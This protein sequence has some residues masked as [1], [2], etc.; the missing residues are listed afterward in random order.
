[1]Y[2]ARDTPHPLCA[3]ASR[4]K[5][6]SLQWKSASETTPACSA[7]IV[8]L[9]DQRPPNRLLQMLPAADFELARPHL[10]VA[11]LA[12]NTLLV[13]AGEPAAQVYLP[14][15]GIISLVI[16]LSDGQAIEVAMIGRDGIV[17]A[18]E[19]LCDGTSLTDAVVL[20]P[21]VASVLAVADL[22]AIA[23]RSPAWRQLLARHEQAMLAQSQQSV[24]CNAVHSVEE[25][26]SRRLLSARDL[27]D[28]ETLPMTQELLARMIGV[29]R[30]AIS[31]VAHALQQ[32]RVLSYS[33]GH[34]EITNVEKLKAAACECYHAVKTK[35]THLFK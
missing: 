8:M 18:A 31:I 5:V 28:G 7:G 2:K 14:H 32:A 25:R 29:Q 1:V 22:K 20:C 17:G 27:W 10:E 9:A 13:E 23:D 19:A 35:Q 24:A 33:R 21:G 11:E 15:S 34:I 30:N 6:P 16:N 4:D 26:L 12:R 3:I